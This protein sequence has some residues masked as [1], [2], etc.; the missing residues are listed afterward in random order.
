[1]SQRVATAALLAVLL[2]GCSS[3]GGGTQGLATWEI[4]F[5][6]EDVIDLVMIGFQAA[7]NAYVGDPVQPEDV[8]EDA[9]PSNGY[10]VVYALP[11]AVRV[12]LG[13]GSGSVGLRVVEDG[14]VNTDPLGFSI[15]ATSALVVEIDYDLDYLGTAWTTRLTDVLF[16]VFVTATRASAADLFDVEYNIVGDCFLGETYCDWDALF[17]ALGR[18]RDGIV[19][20]F[21][22]AIVTIDDPDIFDFYLPIFDWRVDHFRTRGPVGCCS[23][24]EDHVPYADVIE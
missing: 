7:E 13:E 16:T 14:A 15:D 17:A 22:D 24:Y 18:P 21:G 6:Y 2:A 3:S 11:D 5:L 1:M 19:E 9:A 20:G 12:G 8:I 4:D 23:L 10:T